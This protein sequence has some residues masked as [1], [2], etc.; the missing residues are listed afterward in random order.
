M[1]TQ[2]P[3]HLDLTDQDI[4]C[5]S[6]EVFSQEHNAKIKAY[7][8]SFHLPHQRRHSTSN[9]L[10]IK[11]RNQRSYPTYQPLKNFQETPSNI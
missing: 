10:Q 2:L 6:Q 11:G 9:L 5:L 4:S 8:E 1:A 7:Q 3:H